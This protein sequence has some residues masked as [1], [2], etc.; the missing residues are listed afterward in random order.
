MVLRWCLLLPIR[1]LKAVLRPLLL[2]ALRF[3][4]RRPGLRSR[5]SDALH[6]TP[7]L[8]QRLVNIAQHFGLIRNGFMSAGAEVT[9]ESQHSAPAPD[10]APNTADEAGLAQMTASARHIYFELKTAIEQQHKDRH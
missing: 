8:R 3:A 9:A 7:R 1:M 5:L 6:H 2:V 4:L 10:V